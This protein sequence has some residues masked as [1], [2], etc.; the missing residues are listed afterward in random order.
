MAQWGRQNITLSYVKRS[1]AGVCG[2]GT[3]GKRRILEAGSNGKPFWVGK[4]QS[5]G[6]TL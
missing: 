4:E 6:D 3:A 5:T 2:R 1:S